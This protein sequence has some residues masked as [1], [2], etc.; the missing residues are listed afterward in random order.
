[1]DWDGEIYFDGKSVVARCMVNGCEFIMKRNGTNV[2]LLVK[3]SR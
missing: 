2:A 3:E 1:M